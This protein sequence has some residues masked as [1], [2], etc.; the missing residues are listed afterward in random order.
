MY[1]PT[2]R[3]WWWPAEPAAHLIARTH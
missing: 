3:N 1:A 2:N